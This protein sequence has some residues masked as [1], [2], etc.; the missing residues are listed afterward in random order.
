MGRPPKILNPENGV[1]IPLAGGQ[2]CRQSELVAPVCCRYKQ[3]SLRTA[4]YQV[5]SNINKNIIFIS[6]QWWRWWDNIII[7][8][9]ELFR[10]RDYR[11]DDVLLLPVA[12][13]KLMT[14]NWR[15]VPLANLFDIA[16]LNVRRNIDRNIKKLVRSERQ[17]YVMRFYLSSQKADMMGTV[18]SAYCLFHS[19]HVNL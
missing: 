3:N 14:S 19:I 10:F 16:V 18:P 9:L 2:K 1:L 5:I 12:S 13:Q 15:N 11:H 8:F 17:N 4:W 7:L 6:A